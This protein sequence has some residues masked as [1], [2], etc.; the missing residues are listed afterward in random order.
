[1]QCFCLSLL[2]VKNTGFWELCGMCSCLFEILKKY[3]SQQSHDGL[4]RQ[5]FPLSSDS[6]MTVIFFFF[7]FYWLQP[8]V[9]LGL[10]NNEMIVIVLGIITS[11]RVIFV[12][13]KIQEVAILSFSLGL[14]LMA[15]TN[16]LQEL[17]TYN[18][19]EINRRHTHGLQACVH[20]PHT[21]AH[22]RI[23]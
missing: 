10:F 14:R 20:A 11:V 23:L 9:G 3:P 1:V 7:F 22:A 8:W 15:V 2:G 6:E 19:V 21:H 12:Q 4:M 17:D 13:C 5:E 16:E 18:P